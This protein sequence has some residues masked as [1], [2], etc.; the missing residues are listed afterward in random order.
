MSS[1]EGQ[2]LSRSHYILL[3][4]IAYNVSLGASRL[5]G[6]L[7]Y[8]LHY[9]YYGINEFVHVQEFNLIVFGDSMI[10]VAV[11]VFLSA[12]PIITNNVKHKG[13]NIVIVFLLG[14]AATY[15][16]YVKMTNISNTLIY[17]TVFMVGFNLTY[18]FI[19]DKKFKV[20][21]F[22]ALLFL[23][24]I[25]TIF[26]AARVLDQKTYAIGLYDD[27]VVL[28]AVFTGNYVVLCNADIDVDK[29]SLS[30][31]TEDYVVLPMS[32]VFSMIVFEDREFDSIKII[33]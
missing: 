9:K 25:S 18:W 13:L 24:V 10:L 29:N 17:C 26:I 28:G 30:V 22:S 31:Y 2:R 5:L 4:V 32:E 7:Y 33:R 23:M 21:L 1:L 14:I 27:N 11:M 3:G 16:N 20:R 8:F 15:V 12:S 19:R 6:L